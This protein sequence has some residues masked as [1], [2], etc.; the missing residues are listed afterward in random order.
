MFFWLIAYM[1]T[2]IVKFYSKTTALRIVN[3]FCV[4]LVGY[5]KRVCLI[6]NLALC[7]EGELFYD[8]LDW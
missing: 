1:I 6:S 5:K 2:K 3:V 7:S 8:I 4:T